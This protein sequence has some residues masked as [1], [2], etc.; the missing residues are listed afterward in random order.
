MGKWNEKRVLRKERAEKRR[1]ELLSRSREEALRELGK[2][3]EAEEKVEEGKRRL[4]MRELDNDIEKRR[5]EK[6][7]K[8]EEEERRRSEKIK[9]REKWKRHYKK[10]TRKGQIPLDLRMKHTLNKISKRL[11]KK[12]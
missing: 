1:G 11:E 3:K 7:E 12:E 6:R 2:E 4:T 10:R 8:R 9:E 5:A